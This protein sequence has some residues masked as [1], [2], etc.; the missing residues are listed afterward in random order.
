M[1]G[2]TSCCYVDQA[3][4][5]YFLLIFSVFVSFILKM[6]KIYLY[7]PLKILHILARRRAVTQNKVSLFFVSFIC[8]FMQIVSYSDMVKLLFNNVVDKI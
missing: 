6:M 5:P 1:N 8:I 7:Q 3:C 2:M 4:R